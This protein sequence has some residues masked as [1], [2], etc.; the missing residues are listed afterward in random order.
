[1]INT[2]THFLS[3]QAASC[4][5]GGGLLAFPHWYE[6]LPSA[7]DSLNNCIPQITALTDIWL[8]V[9]ALIDILLRL[10]SILAVGI[11]IY[12]GV[13]FI[14]SQGE[15]DK[16]AKARDTIFNALIGLA[17]CVASTFLVGFLAQRFS[18]GS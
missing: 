9:A 3:L 16:T 8:I 2:I 17:I 13:Q 15:P 5:G 12:G 18:G 1:M 11:I 7:Q 4:A 14:M 10:A 6:Y